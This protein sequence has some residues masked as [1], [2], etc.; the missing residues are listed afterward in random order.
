MAATMCCHSRSQTD[1]TLF[2]GPD[3]VDEE[4]IERRLVDYRAL[5]VRKSEEAAAIKEHKIGVMFD[6]AGRPV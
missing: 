3:R 2:S 5:Q 6:E 4:E 1:R